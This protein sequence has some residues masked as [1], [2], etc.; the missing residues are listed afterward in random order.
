MTRRYD[1]LLIAGE[2]RLSGPREE[3]P[4][5]ST[6][7]ATTGTAVSAARRIVL[8]SRCGVV[9]GVSLLA[10][11][12]AVLLFLPGSP[13][14]DAQPA[15]V[16]LE[17]FVEPYDGAKVEEIS[18]PTF[19][20]KGRPLTPTRWRVVS[21]TGND[22]E[23]YLA[24]TRDGMLLDFGGEW[25]RVSLDEGL[26]WSEV[27]PGPELRDWYSYEGAVAVAPG[28][29]V[30]AV[31]QDGPFSGVLRALT[32][33]YDAAAGKWFYSMAE[34]AAP[35]MDRPTVGVLP[36]P[37]NIAGTTVP[38]VSAMRAGFYYK[39]PF[40]YSLDGLNYSVPSSRFVDQ[41]TNAPRSEPLAVERWS[42]L[43]WIQPHELIGITPYGRGKAMAE[44]PW[45]EL[46]D[47]EDN[48]PRTVLD[49]TT[50]RW[51]KYDFP[52]KTGPQEPEALTQRWFFGAGR[53]LADSRGILHHVSLTERTIEYLI[54]RDG[55]KTWSTTSIP[56][57][58]GYEAYEGWGD[59]QK[60]L[61]VNGRLNMSALAVHV[62]EEKDPLVTRDLVYRFS[63][64]D[65]R[66]RVTKIYSIGRGDHSCLP[67]G[68][69]GAD[70]F[71]DF[72][73]LTLLPGGRITASFTDASHQEPAIAI[74]LEK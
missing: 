67:G 20:A 62:V 39:A 38:Y 9:A 30:V 29:D 57:L 8:M 1:V 69:S 65:K 33:K 3:R 44:R 42:E 46:V 63:L 48:A 4:A 66:P 14:A 72:P 15:Q 13:S 58:D 31:G 12:A 5:P 47:P 22:R 6:C 2:T 68:I 24:A 61:R 16:R 7:D 53:T 10:V 49:A 23:N 34:L 54:S 17:A 35:L 73:S 74:Q 32:F 26:T 64:R 11:L 52:S 59:I 25:L 21:G 60:A 50:L 40:V 18:Y 41:A 51:S 70:A 55:G 45:Y 43:D 36:G 19:D 37:F 71:C 28:G 56:L 27:L